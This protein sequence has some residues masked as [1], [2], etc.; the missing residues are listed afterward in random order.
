M[1]G[2][3]QIPVTNDMNDAA[4]DLLVLIGLRLCL[5]VC[6]AL[7]A[8]GHM[9]AFDGGSRSLGTRSILAIADRIN[10]LRLTC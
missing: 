3:L 4:A 7:L 1:L 9:F 5:V 8:V 2:P 6:E 10:Y